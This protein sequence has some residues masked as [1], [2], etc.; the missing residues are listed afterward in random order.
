MYI[1]VSLNGRTLRV[2]G[3]PK[4][5]WRRQPVGCW[6]RASTRFTSPALLGVQGVRF[7][8]YDGPLTR[9]ASLWANSR[10]FPRQ[11]TVPVR[12]SLWGVGTARPPDSRL[13][14]CSDSWQFRTNPGRTVLGLRRPYHSRL[15]PCH[16]RLKSP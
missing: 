3:A 11:H 2:P 9:G 4:K 12:G 7:L 15:P 16:T 6:H 5:G 10:L 1:Y 13:R 14:P 8:D